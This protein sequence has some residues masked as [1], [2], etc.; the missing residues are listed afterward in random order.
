M[1]RLEKNCVRASRKGMTMPSFQRDVYRAVIDDMEKNAGPLG[2]GNRWKADALF[3]ENSERA[4]QPEFND[5]MA[6]WIG[7][8]GEKPVDKDLVSAYQDFMSKFDA[9]GLMDSHFP[10]GE[11]RL[12][13]DLT[14]ADL[15]SIMDVSLIW[16]HVEAGDKD[17]LTILE[18]GGGYGRLAEAFLN[19][20]GK[21][22]TYVLV[23]AVPAS[24]YH[25]YQYI[26]TRF[27][28][29]NVG[30][31]YADDFNPRRYSCFVVPIWHFERVN[32]R[33]LYDGA[34]NVASMQE[35]ESHQVSYCIKLFD[36]LV[37]LGGLIYLSNTRDFYYRGEFAY[38]ANWKLLLKRNTPRSWW[39]YY[40]V[41]ILRKLDGEFVEQ[42]AIVEAGYLPEVAAAYRGRIDELRQVAATYR[43]TIENLNKQLGKE[44]K[45]VI[46]ASRSASG[47]AKPSR[48]AL[49]VA[50]RRAMVRLVGNVPGLRRLRG[51]VRRPRSRG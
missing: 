22:V 25:S 20:F 9:L 15:G 45:A 43:R 30:W 36:R 14:V 34:I 46:T 35:M 48:N 41:E 16:A 31:Y 33:Q 21:Q 1:L 38:P 32:G 5:M 13:D 10:H 6:P 4:V 8:K 19:L 44:P 49:R 51:V 47:A 40:P 24:L 18:V 26:S 17:H 42:N 27:P 37:K 23:D 2:P 3:P 39:P 7:V 12:P 11:A 29:L 28:N 50:L